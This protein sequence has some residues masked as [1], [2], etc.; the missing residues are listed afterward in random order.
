MK[1]WAGNHTYSTDRVERPASVGELQELVASGG[2]VKALGSRHSF[3]DI[4][5]T[6]GALVSL[7]RLPAD[8]QV[9]PRTATA[10][11]GA[12][13]A[14]GAVVAA[15]HE[16]GWALGNLASLPH[17]SVAGAVAT[18]THGSGDR[19]GILAVAV[20]PSNS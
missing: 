18:G 15:L 6:D 8:L 5:D 19:N 3:T 14:Y 7:E 4:G 17:I 10:T 2:R 12:G 9:D 20:S 13:A 11:I 1:N 16:Q